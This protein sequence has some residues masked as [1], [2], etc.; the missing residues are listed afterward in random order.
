[1]NG[2][3]SGHTPT[4]ESEKLAL[5]PVETV[6]QVNRYAWEPGV[7]VQVPSS[8]PGT[9]GQANFSPSRMDTKG[10]PRMTADERRGESVSGL[11]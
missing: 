2:I 10:V 8:S 3:T 7:Q 5:P 11:P 9:G 1:M 4:A 6:E